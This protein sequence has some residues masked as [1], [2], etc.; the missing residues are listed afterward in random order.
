VLLGEQL[1]DGTVAGLGEARKQLALAVAA[2]SAPLAAAAAVTGLAGALAFAGFYV[3]L[4][5][6][7]QE[8]GPPRSSPGA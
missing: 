3:E 5:R 4:L 1:G 7:L 6:R 2:D 8:A